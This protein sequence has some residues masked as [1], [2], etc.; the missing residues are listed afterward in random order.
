MGG[1]PQK[2]GIMFIGRSLKTSCKDFNL[3]IGGGLSWVKW[4]KNGVEKGFISHAIIP[5]LYQF[6]C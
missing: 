3:V 2:D 6:F 4:L 5:S 1:K